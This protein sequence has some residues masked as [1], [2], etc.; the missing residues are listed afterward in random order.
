MIDLITVWIKSIIFVVLFASFLDLLLPNN[1][2]QRFIKVI[3]GL[4]I[5]LSILNPVIS[6]IDRMRT[7]AQVPALAS[8]VSGLSDSE[9]MDTAKQVAGKRDQIVREIY[10]RD[11]SKQIRATVLAVDGVADAIVIVDAAQQGNKSSGKLN[12]VIVYVEPGITADERRI[13]RV[14]IAQDAAESAKESE[15]LSPAVTDKVTKLVTELYQLKASQ[16]E[17]QRIN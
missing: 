9:I 6:V 3:M 8:G 17:V 4:F 10:E 15:K 2:M 14:T 5:M 13:A 11:L 7:T 16:V 1:R 12:R